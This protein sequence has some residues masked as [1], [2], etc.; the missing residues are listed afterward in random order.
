MGFKWTIEI[1][2]DET[3]V[4]DGFDISDAEDFADRFAAKFLPQAYPEEVKAEIIKAPD[5]ADIRKA[6]GYPE[7]KQ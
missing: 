4:A 7:V 5:Q 1:E 3:W 2:V 6:Q